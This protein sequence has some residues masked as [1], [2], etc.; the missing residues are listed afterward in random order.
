MRWVKI[1]LCAIVPVW[2]L[3]LALPS[4]QAASTDRLLQSELKQQQ[5]QRTTQRV[6]DQ[7]SAIIDEF[8]RNGIAG[9]DVR[10]LRAIRSV[11]NRLSEKEMAT[12]IALLQQAQ[13]AGDDTSAKKGVV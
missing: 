12:V 4:L 8:E 10:V 9:D 11:L 3:A 13:K 2:L 6:G 7:L 1:F 5:I